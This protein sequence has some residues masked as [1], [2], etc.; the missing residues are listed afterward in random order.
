MP[1]NF[2]QSSASGQVLTVLTHQGYG[3]GS[4]SL[5]GPAMPLRRLLCCLIMVVAACAAGGWPAMADLAPHVAPAAGTAMAHGGD[6]DGMASSHHGTDCDEAGDRGGAPCGSMVMVCGTGI[7]GTLPIQV[8]MPERRLVSL[9]RWG[10]V[11]AALVARLVA[12]G[13][14]PPRFSF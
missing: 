10:A 1:D 9:V 6:H 14:R 7:A 11:D 12:P 3:E 8:R 4:R 5:F 13:L 2:G